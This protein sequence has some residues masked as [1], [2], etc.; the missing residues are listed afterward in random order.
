MKIKT[1][2]MFMLM[3]AM[4]IWLVSCDDNGTDPDP[5]DPDPTVCDNIDDLLDLAYVSLETKM[6]DLTEPNA[7]EP[8]R[9]EDI[10]FSLTRGLYQD[11][12]DCDNDNLEARFGLAFTEML[13]LTLDQ[14]VNDAFDAW[15]AYLDDASPFEVDKSGSPLAFNLNVQPNRTSVELPFNVVSNTVMAHLKSMMAGDEPQIADIQGILTDVVMPKAVL[16]SS[17]LGPVADAADFEFIVSGRMQGDTYADDIEMD[18]TDMLVCMAG[19]RLLQAAV[20][21]ATAYDV[22]MAAYDSSGIMSGFNQTNGNMMTMKTGAEVNMAQV[23]SIFQAAVDDLSDAID[24]LLGETDTQGNDWIK[25]DPDDMT[26][27]D[28]SELRDDYLPDVRDALNAGGIV[29]SEDWDDDDT[30][31]DQDM[32][33]D[34][35]AF[36]NNPV[37]DWKH[38]LP[39]YALSVIEVPCDVEYNQ[40]NS[41]SEI[42]SMT[43]PVDYYDSWAN[44]GFNVDNFELGDVESWGNSFP[45]FDA[46]CLD[47]VDDIFLEMQAIPDWSGEGWISFSA[48]SLTADTTQDVEVFWSYS[49]ELALSWIYAPMITWAANDVDAWFA[50]VPHPAMNGLLPDFTSGTEYVDFFGI[51]TEGWEKEMRVEWEFDCNWT[52]N[53]DQPIRR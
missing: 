44:C 21:V 40:G 30:T 53:W 39:S 10:D 23:P 52:E 19:V 26:E 7:V 4:C 47:L 49:Y 1:T 33:I 28:L 18:H 20:Y 13:V 42:V 3:L 50:D 37:G 16:V 17:L 51:D 41:G 45:A 34:L 9:P 43:V 46:A 6:F 48:N 22:Q 25:T 12:Y 38:M 15:D 31:P 27:A 5:D 35:H 36:F 24:S 2:L 8:D 29:V 32:T 11:A 14:D